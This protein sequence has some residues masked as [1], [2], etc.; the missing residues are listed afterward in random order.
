MIAIIA[1]I[2]AVGLEQAARYIPGGANILAF[3]SSEW[4]YIYKSKL[5]SLLLRGGLAQS[6]ITEVLLL[7]IFLLAVI[8]IQ[9]L[10]MM[11]LGVWGQIIFATLLLFY[12]LGNPVL[13]NID[14][15][16]V[17]G[18]EKKFGILFWFAV[19]GP[20]GAAM[21]WYLAGNKK[22]NDTSLV[23]KTHAIA[24]WVPARLT[25]FVYAL[26]GNFVAGFGCWLRCVLV[27][28][29]NSSKVLIDC[30]QAALDPQESQNEDALVFRAYIAW[31]IVSVLIV[32]GRLTLG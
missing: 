8:I 23:S 6:N 16:L 1:I 10:F 29:M 14:S 27:P 2:L 3:R 22:D 26:V 20:F 28:T 13:D 32:L 18:H 24:A 25:G 12:M 5:S 4:L 15:V 7:V 9:L 11:L 30:G 19:M 17:A 31:L 21:Y